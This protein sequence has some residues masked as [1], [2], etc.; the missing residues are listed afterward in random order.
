M[1]TPLARVSALRVRDDTVTEAMDAPDAD[2]A[3]LERTY[4][5][6]GAV[7]ALVSG[8]RT[9]YRKH[10]RPRLSTTVPARIL[11]I[12]S[13]GGD[14]TAALADWAR[15]DGLRL[16]VTGIDPDERADAYARR[17]HAGQANLEFRRAFSSELVAAGESFE[18][19]VSNHML[20]HLDGTELGALLADSERLAPVC[21]HAD[22]TRG[23]LAYAGFGMLTAA[24]SP[25]F[26]GSYIRADGLVSIRRSHRPEEL[27]GHLPHGW[28]VTAESPFRYL[29]SRGLGRT[30]PSAR[31]A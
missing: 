24:L 8:W 12:G 21:L 6:F 27:V 31:D 30:D 1:T 18:I 4:A 22:I 16:E 20:H 19:V 9:T 7:N 26:R 15:R 5:Q 28:S 10:I 11:D 29:L 23:P 14:L 3:T 17:A 13:G 25:C 2:A